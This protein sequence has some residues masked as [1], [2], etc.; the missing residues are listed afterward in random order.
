MAPPRQSFELSGRIAA[1][2]ASSAFAANFRWQHDG[3]RDAFEL[4]S[5]FGQ[6]LARLTGDDS[7]VELATADGRI[8]RAAGWAALT[9]R[10]LG[11]PL[12]VSGLAFWVQGAPREGAP[13]A[14]DLDENREPSLLRQDGWTIAYQAF[15]STPDG[16]RRPARM[17]LSYADVELR[18]VIDSSQ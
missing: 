15:A 2:Y 17:T 16:A 6:T 9:E 13:F 10:G 7:G 11:W 12:P 5:P 18:L 8:E 4:A 14:L 3:Q 1:H